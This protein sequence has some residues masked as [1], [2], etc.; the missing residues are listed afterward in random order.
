[1]DVS[2]IIV[3]YNT[4]EITRACIKSVMQKTVGVEYEIIVVD[5]ASTDGTRE[6]LENDPHIRYVYSEINGGF[7]YANNIGMRI[8][9]G[10]YFFLLNSDTLL[11]NNAIKEFYD[12]AETHDSNILY[13]AYLQKRDGSYCKSFHFF[14]AFSVI[15]F[16]RRKWRGQ[17]YTPTY[18]D[19][20]VDCICGADLFIPR[21][22]IDV[23]GMF[24]ENI[25]LYGEEGE[26]QYRMMKKGF[27]RM[28]ISTPKI[29]HLEGESGGGKAF[30]KYGWK[31][32]FYV[33]RKH[34]PWYVYVLARL[35]YAV[36]RKIKNK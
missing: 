22:A 31:S 32:H 19:T 20:Y 7:G 16:F 34:S 24:D 17:D 12:Y 21:Q 4:L 33:V 5:N 10:K 6:V 23:C 15:D 28:L 30:V 2:V 11:L 35:Y 13:G 9:K 36:V 29:I 27:R 25:F 3:T 26:L 8:A 18:G 14:P 1:M